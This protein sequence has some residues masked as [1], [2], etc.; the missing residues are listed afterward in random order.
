MPFSMFPY[1]NRAAFESEVR[2]LASPFLNPSF[3]LGIPD[4]IT[5][6]PYAYGSNAIRRD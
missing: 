2:M 1:T 5:Y 6:N 3:L 4:F